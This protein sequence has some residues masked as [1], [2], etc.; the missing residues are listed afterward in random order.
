[1]PLS[2]KHRSVK[3]QTQKHCTASCTSTS[4]TSSVSVTL[5][6]PIYT[7]QTSPVFHMP[8][9]SMGPVSAHASNQPQSLE[10]ATNCSTPSEVFLMSFFPMASLTNAA[11]LHSVRQ[12]NTCASLAKHL[13]SH[14]LSQACFSRI[15]SLLCLLQQNVP[16]QVC[17]RLSHLCPL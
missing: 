5:W 1:M 9:L 11:Q 7:L 3:T 13:P 15:S 14:V 12:T 6:S 8:C 16:S 2:G 4:K 10:V 17:L